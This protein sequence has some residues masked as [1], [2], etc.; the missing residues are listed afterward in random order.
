LKN[1]HQLASSEKKKEKKKSL[2]RKIMKKM[3][4][5]TKAKTMCQ[6][7]MVIRALEFLS[8]SAI[9]AQ[10]AQHSM[11]RMESDTWMMMAEQVVVNGEISM[12]LPKYSLKEVAVSHRHQ[13]NNVQ[14]LINLPS[15]F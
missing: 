11:K 7:C 5:N 10:N 8:P 13:C 15:S 14:Q 6:C 12:A 3:I 1:V 9:V 2:N 4:N